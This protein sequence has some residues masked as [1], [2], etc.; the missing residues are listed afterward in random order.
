MA[1]E[2][3]LSLHA[4]EP[5]TVYCWPL[6]SHGSMHDLLTISEV[7]TGR[8]ICES[9]SCSLE[10]IRFQGWQHR[11][12]LASPRR[13]RTSAGPLHY[14]RSLAPGQQHNCIVFGILGQSIRN[15]PSEAMQDGR[16]Y[17]IRLPEGVVV[18]MWTYGTLQQGLKG[19]FNLPPM[20]FRLEG[21]TDFIYRAPTSDSPER[22][23]LC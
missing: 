2:L 22:I 1:V 8:I 4:E 14:L 21:K 3:K 6:T 5:I 17:S 12:E 9:Q 10:H 7:E 23:E 20:P 16:Q 19:P 11:R 18:P 15:L 13:T